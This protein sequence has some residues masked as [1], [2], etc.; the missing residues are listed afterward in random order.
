MSTAEH[1]RLRSVFHRACALSDPDRTAWLDEACGDDAALRA[2]VERLLEADDDSSATFLD[3][4][5]GRTLI[6]EAIH[7]H[8][9]VPDRLGRFHVLG[10]LGAGSMGV[11]YRARQDEPSREVALK[12]I[13]PWLLS[14]EAL[15]RF[16]FEGEVLAR[17]NHVG[18]AQIYE[19]GRIRVRDDDG[20]DRP[21]IAMELV[22]G[23][24]ITRY[25]D[26]HGLDRR[27]RLELLA[28]VADA[29]QHAH[30]RGIVHR[31]LKPSNVLVDAHG[32]PKV[33]DFGVA[34]VTDADMTL[35]RESFTNTGV[36]GTLR[37]MSPEQI[38]GRNDDIDTRSDVYALGVIAYE[39]LTGAPLYEFKA[40][41]IASA[42][43]IICEVDPF[44]TGNRGAT[45]ELDRDLRAILG[46]AI[47]K[48]PER[49]YE[50]AA[51]FAADIRRT[52]AG[53][54]VLARPASTWYQ[55]S[56]LAQRNRPLA[57][58]V[59]IAVLAV[60]AG[61][62]MMGFG[63]IEASQRAKEARL[64]VENSRKMADFL[65]SV[66]FA[67][68]PELLGAH[69][70]FLDAIEL[71]SARIS[72][73]LNDHPSV[74]ARAH[75]SMGFVFR[76]LSMFAKAEN[77]LRRAAEL[78]RT[79]AGAES[80]AYA[81]ALHALAML[82]Y[83][84]RGPGEEIRQMLTHA[85]SIQRRHLDGA[86]LAWAVLGRAIVAIRL[87]DLN[88]ADDALA[89][90]EVLL[91]QTD[92]SNA[93]LESRIWLHRAEVH[94][95]RGELD[96]AELLI[97][98]GREALF[99]VENQDYIRAQFERLLAEILIERAERLD[100][101]I[102]LLDSAE[103]G[104]RELLPDDHVELARTLEARVHLEL[105]RNRYTEAVSNAQAAVRM[106][107][108]LLSP[109]HPDRLVSHALLVLAEQHQSPDRHRVEALQ[110]LLVDVSRRLQF[111]HVLAIEL[112][113]MLIDA[114]RMIG[115]ESAVE[116]ATLE[117]KQQQV[118]RRARL[119]SAMLDS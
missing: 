37:Y 113:E 18:I 14:S 98:H 101:A 91:S 78:E 73:D 77:H 25:A 20:C 54:T 114:Y 93:V 82:Q 59:L 28:D 108:A 47:A 92:L 36:V 85:E 69:A 67:S 94:V 96:D 35:S 68:D 23:P 119:S 112:R 34:K 57:A 61:L 5:V 11:V 75:R 50:S 84:Y 110:K 103:H 117:L 46:K 87:D 71:A 41:S 33:V 90:A 88:E 16:R 116:V 97:Q 53:E 95:L 76:R 106:R 12:L 99:N 9:D 74:E 6:V 62:A 24:S 89:E 60:G 64:E 43:Q 4:T 44:A 58:A 80:A 70:T 2:E 1:Q 55:L 22:E 65:E 8:V 115:A 79:V 49:R 52:I 30:G 81:G 105:A 13:H 48:E 3:P 66:V 102:A 104:F 86:S 40:S 109:G 45:S 10:R 107:E 38:R 72:R 100:E 63:L 17:L 32:Q 19:V 39:L 31:D 111:D 118:S 15:T 42:A 7:D 26:E 56:R 51:A 83:D 29:V 21:Y 27:A